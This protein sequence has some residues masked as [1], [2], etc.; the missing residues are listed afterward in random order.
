MDFMKPCGCNCQN[1]NK[2]NSCSNRCDHQEPDIDKCGMMYDE[3][4]EMPLAM[5]YVPW[6]TWRNVYDASVGLNKG[7]VFGELVL[8]F[9][10]ASPVC[11]D[12]G[13]NMGRRWEQ[14]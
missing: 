7:S 6:Q 13:C 14:R 4:H 5:A 9:E 12:N 11:R 3:F 8:P 2:M 1:R 10:C